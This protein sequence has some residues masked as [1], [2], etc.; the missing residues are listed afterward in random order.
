M[1]EEVCIYLMIVGLILIKMKRIILLLMFAFLL[2]SLTSLTSA[3]GDLGVFK[4]GETIQLYQMCDACSYVNITSVI[5]PNSTVLHLDVAMN[6][7]GTDYTYSF[8]HTLILGKYTYTVC[9]D[10]IGYEWW[11]G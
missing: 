7:D 1:Q 8:S 6:K 2:I 3:E 5:Y 11:V 10:Q 4:Q 9:G